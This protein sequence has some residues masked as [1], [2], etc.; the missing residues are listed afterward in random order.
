MNLFGDLQG[1]TL[2]MRTKIFKRGEQNNT[3]HI[4]CN[5]FTPYINIMRLCMCACVRMCVLFKII[6][7]YLPILKY[8]TSFKF[9]IDYLV[10]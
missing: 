6:I 7:I 3:E 5:N 4:L 10:T 1:I 8:I 9:T 2:L